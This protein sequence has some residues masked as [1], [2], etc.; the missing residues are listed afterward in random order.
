[1]S[2][3]FGAKAINRVDSFFGRPPGAHR[4]GNV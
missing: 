4:C 3:I 1:M 2:D